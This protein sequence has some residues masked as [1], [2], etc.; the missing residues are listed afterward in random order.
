[1]PTSTPVLPAEW[2]PQ[3]AVLLTWPHAYSD[4]R[5]W[6]AAVD[7][8]FTLLATAISRRQAVIIGCYD[9]AYRDHVQALLCAA[10]AVMERIR[11]YC[12]P[13]N[14]SWARDHGPITVY[15]D[16]VPVLLDFRFNGW[17]GKF[18][19]ELDD[20]ITARLHSLGAFGATPLQA[21][22]LILEGGS[23]ES[24]GQGTLLTTSRCLLAPTRNGLPRDVLEQRLSDLL[25][26]E[27][28]LWLDQ[29]HLSGDD[30]DSHIDTLARFCDP[31]TIAYQ[32]CTN[33]ADSDYASLQAMEQELQI[34]RTLVGE[35]YRLVP[36]PLPR[37]CYGEDGRRLPASYANFLMINDAVLAPTYDD[38]ADAQALA[39]LRACFPGREVIAIPSLPLIQQ[40][41]SLH[42]VTM[43]LPAG[44]L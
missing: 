12:V 21:V 11:L 32:T 16:G 43:Q 24:D 35:P 1:M 22:E 2:Q 13:S 5:P 6:L 26:I 23:I 27:R 34:F 28:F 9:T 7:R 39:C 41:G 4:W 3:A 19:H 20:E 42:C 31:G 40:Y 36:L 18:A 33:S 29:G 10:G 37:P 8:T 17:G 44:V 15:R 14:D 30:T 25:E 38:P